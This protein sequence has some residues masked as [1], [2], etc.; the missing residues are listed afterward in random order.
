MG[1][2]SF[3]LDGAGIVFNPTFTFQVL[4]KPWSQV[5]SLLPLGTCLHFFIA[6]GVEQVVVFHQL[7]LTRDLEQSTS[8]F[9]PRKSPHDQY[10]D[11]VVCYSMHSEGLELTKIDLV[12]SRVTR[13]I[14]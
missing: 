14:H 8:L 6:Q 7:L 11:A 1:L 2:V 10:E 9:F 5:S 4:D 12:N 3:K 13:L